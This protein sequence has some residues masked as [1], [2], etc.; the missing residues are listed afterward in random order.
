[1]TR[2]FV[3]GIDYRSA[4]IALRERLAPPADRLADVLAEIREGAALAEALLLSTCNRIEIYGVG[5]PPADAAAAAARAL[6]RVQGVEADTVASCLY[7]HGDAE[8]VRHCLRVAASLES[9]VLGEPQILGQVKAAFA[10]AQERGSL[11]PTLQQLMAHAFGVAKRV[12]TETEL[13][14]HAVSV[15]SVAVELARK[16]FGDLDGRRALLVGSGEMGALA[17]RHLVEQGVRPL[18][19]TNRTAGRAEALAADVGGTSVPFETWTEMLSQ[20]DIVVTAASVTAPIVRAADVA[21]AIARRTLPL[22]LIDIAVPRNVAPGVDALPNVFCYDVDDLQRVADANTRER[23]R[24]ARR[25]AALVDREVETFL[26]RLRD[27]RAAPTIVSLRDKLDGIRR[28]ELDRALT[29]LPDASPEMRLALEAM[30]NRILNKILHT[31]LVTLQASSRN[32]RDEIG[33]LVAELFGLEPRSA[34]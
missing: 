21:R 27:R 1:M 2:P 24:E 5:D 20:V 6:C 29:R 32:G 16:I 30:T 8:A 9:M 10:L 19:V 31:P 15:S 34:R 23:E 18:Y 3:A 26:A 7:T 28:A 33:A 4:P 25:A 17:A 14:R 12:R 22:F 13:G 11:G